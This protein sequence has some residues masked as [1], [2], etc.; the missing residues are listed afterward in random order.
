M[1]SGFTQLKH[2]L[3]TTLCLFRQMYKALHEK[4]LTGNPWK[5]YLSSWLFPYWGNKGWK[6]WTIRY[7]LHGTQINLDVNLLKPVTTEQKTETRDWKEMYPLKPMTPVR[8]EWIHRI[9]S[10]N[11]TEMLPKLGNQLPLNLIY[12]TSAC[13]TLETRGA[14]TIW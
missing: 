1:S 9:L 12:D 8:R 2:C 14:Q 3:L 13:C 5:M 10:H 7:C 6:S 4:N 11:Q